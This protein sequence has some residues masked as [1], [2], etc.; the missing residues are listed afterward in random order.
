MKLYM[1]AVKE[2]TQAG[3]FRFETVPDEQPQ[4][5]G[6]RFGRIKLEG[7]WASFSGVCYE[8]ELGS[9]ILRGM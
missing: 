8:F 5:G 9:S 4:V 1:A 3:L 6:R 7:P 2:T